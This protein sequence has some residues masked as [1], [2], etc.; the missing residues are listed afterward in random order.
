MI[1]IVNGGGINTLDLSE[2]ALPTTRPQK[3]GTAPRLI[4]AIVDLNENT[5]QVQEIYQTE[6]QDPD[7][8]SLVD[9]SLLLTNSTSSLSLSGRFQNVIVG[10][11]ATL[12]AAPAVGGAGDSTLAARHPGRPLGDG[13]H[14][15]RRP[16]LVRPGVQHRRQ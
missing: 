8:G 10:S 11:G 4:G 6:L 16:G 14:G 3:P 15:L 2:A 1:H 12:F 13:E 5:G 9:P 7:I